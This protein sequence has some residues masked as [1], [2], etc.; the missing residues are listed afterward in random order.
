MTAFLKRV[1]PLPAR[2][3]GCVVQILDFPNVIEVGKDF[4]A[5]A[6]VQDQVTFRPGNALEE[7]FPTDQC[8]VLM[9]YLSSS[10]P[11]NTLMPTYAKAF[12]ATKP[13]GFIFI[14]DFVIENDRQGP[15][16]TALWALQH[17]VFT[18]GAESLTP[19]M[20]SDRLVEAGYVDITWYEMIPGMTKLAVGVKPE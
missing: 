19:N 14:H 8:A 9:S 16:L 13:G 18:P 6:G 17:M 5:Q 12:E 11:G 3:G 15:P 2:F 10:I 4:V 7:E 1:L 20:I